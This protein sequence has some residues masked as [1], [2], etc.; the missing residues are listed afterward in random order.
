M[1]LDPPLEPAT[2]LRR[3]QRFLADVEDAAGRVL[4]VHVP[5]S[6]SMATCLAPRAPV[7]LSRS[8]NP[9]RK[10]SHTL[11]MVRDEAGWI[12]VNTLRA[13]TMARE[14]LESGLVPGFGLDW[15]WRA[16]VKRGE[17]RLDF[18]GSRA[19]REVWVEV[20]S[21]T[22]RLEDG[23]AGFPDS[24]TTRGLKHLRELQGIVEE[25]GRA[26]LL[27]MVQRE[28]LAGF[29]P[30]AHIDPAWAAALGEAVATGVEVQALQVRGDATGLRL[31]G[32]LPLTLA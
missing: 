25:G 18:H 11:E 26:L 21:V 10:H 9:A 24:V 30:A 1:N 27:L 20:K 28:G 16:E 19:D 14:A 22:L 5:N 7:L 12:V 15:I 17:S 29:R 6:G 4:T 13:N 31:A 8:A 3:Y 32:A 23:W 2:L